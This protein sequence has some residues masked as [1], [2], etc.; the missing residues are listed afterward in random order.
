M[1]PC[2]AGVALAV[3]AIDP[4][5]PRLATSPGEKRINARRQRLEAAVMP[6]GDN[7]RWRQ[8]RRQ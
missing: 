6:M 8:G 1:C 2:A 4:R 3:T 7:E 5:H